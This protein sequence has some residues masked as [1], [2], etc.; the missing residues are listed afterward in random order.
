M[1]PKWITYCKTLMHLKGRRLFAHIHESK[2]CSRGLH[3]CTNT[4]QLCS[5]SH[6]T[7]LLGIMRSS[8]LQLTTL[9][10]VVSVTNSMCLARY[11]LYFAHIVPLTLNVKLTLFIIP[12][13]KIW[14]YRVTMS[15]IAITC[16]VRSHPNL[17]HP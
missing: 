4:S 6:V 7:T 17:N 2:S 12:R 9:R 8:P 16:Q 10:I 5:L 15:Q 3:L 14:F 11:H 13:N 1:T